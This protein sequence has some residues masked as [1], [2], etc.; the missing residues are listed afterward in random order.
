MH[1]LYL[2]FLELKLRINS[3]LSCSKNVK[4][5]PY[6]IDRVLVVH[7]TCIDEVFAWWVIAVVAKI[8]WLDSYLFLKFSESVTKLS[9]SGVENSSRRKH[10]ASWCIV[11]CLWSFLHQKFARVVRWVIYVHKYI[12]CSYPRFFIRLQTAC[13]ITSLVVLA[14]NNHDL[15][16]RAR[17]PF[18][19]RLSQGLEAEASKTVVSYSFYWCSQSIHGHD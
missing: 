9:F 15:L 5:C 10:V 8:A 19:S 17:L 18:W 2:F 3:S 16:F 6:S 11:F 7:P 14:V 13:L 1:T 12:A 4:T